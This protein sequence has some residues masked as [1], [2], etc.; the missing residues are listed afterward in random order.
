MDGRAH[1][2]FE[3]HVEVARRKDDHLQDLRVERDAGTRV[4]R[5]D[6]EQRQEY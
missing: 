3:Q 4:R 1:R 5:L 2:V 6:V